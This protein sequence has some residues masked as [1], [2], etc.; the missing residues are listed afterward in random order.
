MTH[1]KEF[2]L[3]L[4]KKFGKQV[5]E[6]LQEKSN[7]MTGTELNQEK[8]YIPDFSAAVKTQN[9]LT[10]KS[11]QEDGFVCKS[12]AGRVVR[13]IQNYDSDI[14]KDEPENL[15]SQWR[16]VW[17][18]NPMHALPFISIAT[19]PYSTG[20]CCT[21]EDHVWQSGQDNNTWEPGTVNI[22]W[23]DLGTIEDVMN[24]I[25][26][27]PEDPQ[28]PSDSEKDIITAER[29]MEYIYGKKYLDPEDEKIYLCKRD[30]ESDGGKII[31]HFLPHELIGQYFEVVSE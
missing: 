27:T 1:E 10:R 24:G 15:P 7:T 18:T 23:N 8:G 16:F 12:S 25:I 2:A 11:G 17:S 22:K 19:S 13:L 5:A 30:G 14:Y 29:G 26:N 6:N 9:M 20:E 21:F 28:E 3:D 4:I 31:L